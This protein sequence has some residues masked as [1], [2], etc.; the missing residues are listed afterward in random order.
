[1]PIKVTNV[2]LISPPMLGSPLVNVADDNTYQHDMLLKGTNGTS[3]TFIDSHT[4]Y[5]FCL[6]TPIFCSYCSVILV[7][8]L[9]FYSD[10]YLVCK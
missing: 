3:V 7:C 1:M 6:T 4:H 9:F 2:Q 5:D 8:K 10:T